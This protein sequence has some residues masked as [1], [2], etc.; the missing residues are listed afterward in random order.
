M[1]INTNLPQDNDYIALFPALWRSVKSYIQSM[2]GLE[3]SEKVSGANTVYTH[4]LGFKIENDIAGIT[5][6]S[7]L[8]D[9]SVPVANSIRV[10]ANQPDGG[11]EYYDGTN[12][13]LLPIALLY[14]NTSS[15]TFNAQYGITYMV[16]L[17][18]NDTILTVTGTGFN[19]ITL[20]SAPYCGQAL[21]Q[22]NGTLTFTLTGTGGYWV[23][24]L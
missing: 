1:A 3:H 15:G 24:P 14:N 16:F 4:N 11:L 19:T 13:N 22:F 7:V 21:F 17:W 18:G 23:I 9:G 20:R 2:L 6:D 12:W 5:S 8:K 10:K